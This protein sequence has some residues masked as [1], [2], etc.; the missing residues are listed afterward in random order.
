[1][2]KVNLSEILPGVAGPDLKI[3]GLHYDSRQIE[4]GF[5]F[6]AVPGFKEDGTKYLAGAFANGAAVAI[7]EKG[8]AVPA[9]YHEHCREVENIRR[10]M[11]EA[12]AAFYDFPAKKLALFGVTG[13]KGKTSSTFLLESVL[14]ESGRKTALVGGVQCWHPGGRFDS[15]LT[16]MESLDLQKFLADAVNAGAEAAVLEVSSHALS[17]DRV[18]GCEFQGLIFTNLYEDHLDF[19]KTM[20][21]YFQAKEL[22]FRP[23]YR[24]LATVAVANLD[25]EYGERLVKDC[26]GNWAAFGKFKGDFPV[27]KSEYSESGVRLEIQSPHSGI[28]KIESRLF[29]AFNEQNVAGVAVL[30]LGLGFPVETI[31]RGIAALPAVPGRVELVPSTLPFSVFVDYAHM[32]PALENVLASLRPFCK[33]TL[34]VVVGAG[35]DRPVERRTG[36][37]AAAARLADFTVIT[38]D[39]PRTEDPKKIIAAVEK[40]FLEAGGGAYQIEPDRRDAIRLALQKAKAG[41]IVCIA[42]KGHESGQTIGRD[43][44]PFDDRAEAAAI[45]RDLERGDS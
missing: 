37:G 35:G 40:A 45:L 17:L 36:L 12:A 13:T 39:N 19:Y 31:Q 1:M 11:A 24:T 7:V 27:I 14:R 33:G 18:W 9:E 29:G 5:V 2:R 3:T 21:P 41:D 4:P 10:A 43:T 28:V 26:P 30:A 6:F 15:K 8:S 42:G 38:S 44:F 34:S 25:S 23:P 20:D 32:G 16:T 22:L